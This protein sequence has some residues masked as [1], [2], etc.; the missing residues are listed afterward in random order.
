MSWVELEPLLCWIGILALL[1]MSLNVICGIT[2]LLQLGHAGFFAVGAYTAGL[3]AIYATQPELGAANFAIGAA[4]AMAVSVFFSLVIGLPCLRLRGDYLAV[5]TLAFGELLRITLN[6][7]ELPG[8]AMFPGERIGGPT[9]IGFTEFPEE[10]WPG[11]SGYSAGYAG[12][13]LIWLTVLASYLILR[14]I[15]LSRVGRAFMC[16]RE[17]EIAARAMGI[18]VPGYKL[19]AFMLSAAFAGLAGALLFHHRL[20]IS[21]ND[22]TLIRSIEVLLM[23]VLGGMGS[24]SGSVIA[25]VILGLLPQ[26]LSH[27]N[28]QVYRELIYALLLIALIRVSPGGIFGRREIPAWALRLSLR[29]KAEQ[30][31]G[32]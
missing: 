3:T 17:D 21:P 14:N 7:L 8:G 22:F 6:N 20:H 24:L 13:G 32:V 28:L 27:L 19:L 5:A 4:A 12:L 9:G 11:L 29:R 18:L 23:V 30:G 1:S 25:A 15:K 31:G 2:G 10:L 16:I 26:A